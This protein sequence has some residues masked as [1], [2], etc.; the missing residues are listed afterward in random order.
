MAQFLHAIWPFLATYLATLLC[1]T[2][3]CVVV[4]ERRFENGAKYRAKKRPSN[5]FWHRF[6]EADGWLIASKVDPR[7]PA[8]GRCPV[9]V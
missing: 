4:I 3:R 6:R 1:F 2:L 9:T 5:W 7:V 8:V